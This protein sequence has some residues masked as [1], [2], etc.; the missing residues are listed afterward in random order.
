MYLILCA[1]VTGIKWFY[2]IYFSL[3]FRRRVRARL[4]SG[5]TRRTRCVAAAARSRS[6]SRRRLAPTAATPAPE[7][8]STAGPSR[9]AGG[10]PPAPAGWGTSRT[11]AGGSGTAS[12]RARSQSR[13][14]RISNW[15]MSVMIAAERDSC[16]GKYH[17]H[18]GGYRQVLH[19]FGRLS[20]R[21][22]PSFQLKSCLS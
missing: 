1:L 2:D 8:G 13:R 19:L 12:G 20:L 10:R 21:S 5:A 14:R 16:K 3:P 4:V 18:S 17:S 9:P 11:S 6:T 22:T 15:L 7:H